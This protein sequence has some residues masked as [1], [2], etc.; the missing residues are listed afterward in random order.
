MFQDV[1]L[2]SPASEDLETIEKRFP[3]LSE[4]ILSL[5]H[6]CLNQEP[7]CRG[8]HEDL[9]MHPFFQGLEEWYNEEMK[10]LLEKDNIA[11]LSKIRRKD[12]SR[13]PN[14]KEKKPSDTLMESEKRKR[15]Q[16]STTNKEH[17]LYVDMLPNIRGPKSFV[18][19]YFAERREEIVIPPIGVNYNLNSLTPHPNENSQ[20]S[21]LPTLSEFKYKAGRKKANGKRK[22]KALM[23]N[24]GQTSERQARI[25]SSSSEYYSLPTNRSRGSPD[26]SLRANKR[27]QKRK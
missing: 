12:G 23:N 9:L 3:G 4:Q 16:L 24:N 20:F 2:P 27:H 17:E 10:A 18:I 26:S 8:T 13:T 5:T 21:T 6:L 7:E 25:G 15:Y 1:E 22:P 19:P 14:R 11:D